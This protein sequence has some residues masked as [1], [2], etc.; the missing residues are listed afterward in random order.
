MQFVG[1]GKER[2]A[3]S[4]KAELEWVEVLWDRKRNGKSRT[5]EPVQEFEYGGHPWLAHAIKKRIDQP[6]DVVDW[7]PRSIDRRI[8]LL[9][10]QRDQS[11]SQV[12]VYRKLKVVRRRSTPLTERFDAEFTDLEIGKVCEERFQLSLNLR[13]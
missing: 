2:F 10:E 4:G 8:L 11:A 6:M 9:R 5:R 7:A 13:R 3:V 12:A 1:V